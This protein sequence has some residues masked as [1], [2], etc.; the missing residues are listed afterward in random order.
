MKYNEEVNVTEPQKQS[1]LASIN[2]LIKNRQAKYDQKR[3][4]NLNRIINE[5]EQ[6]RNEFIDML[7]WPLTEKITKPIS[8]KKELLSEEDDGYNIYRMSFE[9]FENFFFYGLL[10]E[11]RDKKLP[12]VI[13]QHGGLGTPESC[14]GIYNGDTANYNHMTERI[15]QRGVHAFAPQLLLWSKEKYGIDYD[16]VILDAQLKQLGGSI[17]A[18]EIYCIRSVIAYFEAQAYVD[19]ERIGMAG[20]SY[21]GFY[22]LYTAAI[23]KKIKAA[24]CSSFFN[25]LYRYSWVDFTWKSSAE[26]FLN[27]EAALL[28]Y[29]RKLWLSVGSEDTCF[30]LDTAQK[31][32]NR[33]CDEIEICKINKTWLNFEIYKSNHVFCPDDN[34]VDEFTSEL[35]K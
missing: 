34:F 17:A 21:G 22:T 9:I 19:A 32:Y 20:L 27:S 11:Y 25:D 5:P 2:S 23:E 28:C 13:C 15:V 7:G 26:K 16:R 4:D 10:F 6:S 18:L 35:K 30:E 3:I 24:L 8:V 33:L 12:F 31:E 29:P 14:S 1:Y